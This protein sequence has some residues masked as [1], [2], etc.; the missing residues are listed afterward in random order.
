M[1]PAAG[2]AGPSLPGSSG[3]F[4]RRGRYG[5]GPMDGMTERGLPEPDDWLEWV[6]PEVQAAIRKPRFRRL[7]AGE[8]MRAQGTVPAAYLRSKRPAQPGRP[9]TGAARG[10]GVV[11]RVPLPESNATSAP[12]QIDSD[13]ARRLT[14]VEDVVAEAAQAVDRRAEQVRAMLDRAADIAGRKLLP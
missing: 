7:T 13:L 4:D 5:V 3:A 9:A 6:P 12:A 14:E 8:R 11:P 10:V 2:G 1:V